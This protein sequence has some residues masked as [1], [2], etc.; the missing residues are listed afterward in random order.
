MTDMTRLL[1]GALALAGALSIAA[2]EKED[3][4]STTGTAPVPESTATQ[5]TAPDST[6]AESTGAST[7]Q[8]QTGTTTP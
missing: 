2:C 5:S 1:M 3:A 8:T 7:G 4:A 6:A